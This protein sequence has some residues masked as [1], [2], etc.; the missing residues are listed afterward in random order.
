MFQLKKKVIEENDPDS[1]RLN[2][3]LFTKFIRDFVLSKI[4]FSC[5]QNKKKK[6]V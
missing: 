2:A 6:K 1:Q 5:T 4:G 3:Q